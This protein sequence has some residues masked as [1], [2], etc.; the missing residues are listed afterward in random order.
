M[1]GLGP[2]SNGESALTFVL[3]SWS[4]GGLLG[5]LSSSPGHLGA[6]GPR[7]RPPFPLLCALGACF[8]REGAE[9]PLVLGKSQDG[10]DAVQPRGA[11]A[12]AAEQVAGEREAGVGHGGAAAG[13][14][15]GERGRR[16]PRVG[17][18]RDRLNTEQRLEVG[19]SGRGRP[20]PGIP[21]QGQT[22]RATLAP[23]ASARP[24]SLQEAEVPSP[25]SWGS[26][27]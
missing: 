15:H 1:G 21:I 7:A 14:V 17:Q 25:G 6:G 22:R 20:N 9:D 4:R 16:G 26:G 18:S 5:G 19:A 27:R 10:F 3:G 11:A 2:R 8:H 24:E 23:A 13:Q 12:R